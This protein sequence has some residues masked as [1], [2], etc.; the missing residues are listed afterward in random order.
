MHL[1]AHLTSA[2]AEGR[3]FIVETST[4]LRLATP[5]GAGMSFAEWDLQKAGQATKALV[6]GQDLEIVW[7]DENV[8][9]FFPR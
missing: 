8:P 9:P 7:V 5:I 6:L 1:G 3:W 4:G 2:P